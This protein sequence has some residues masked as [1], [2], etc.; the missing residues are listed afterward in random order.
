MIVLGLGPG[1]EVIVPSLSFIA[2]ANAPRY[3]GATPVFADVDPITFNMTPASIEEVI[4]ER[5]RAVIVVH[6]LGMPADIDAI[7]VL[8][9][10]HEIAVVEDAACAIGST[11]R[12]GLIGS[13]SDLVV[14][15]FH[16]RKVLTTGEGGM[17][18]VSDGEVA[19]RLRRLRQ[20]GMSVAGYERSEA[21]VP[22]VEEYL[23][24]GFNY[25]MTDIQAAIGL[26]QLRR[27]DDVI[28]RRRQQAAF[29]AEAFDSL[30][31]IQA[32]VDPPYGTTN[33]QSYALV[34]EEEAVATRDEMI[35]ALGR[36]GIASKPALMA[37]HLE[38]TFKGHPHG[39]LPV[40]EQIHHQGLLLPL[41]HEMT[42]QQLATVAQEVDRLATG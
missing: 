36:Q 20:H 23:E 33:Y 15:S 8:C 7:W 22:V 19:A 5:T 13:H 34:V 38:P 1:D 26:V 3:V 9:D 11:Y 12:G 35:E 16:P 25:R 31:G 18:A 42:D 37:A 17:I 6:Q 28:E 24:K 21:G 10:R 4:T 41:F 39:A 27:L 40:T 32:P 2:P 29:Y 30:R 14:F